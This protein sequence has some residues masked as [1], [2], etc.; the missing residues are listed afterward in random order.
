MQ[1]TKNALLLALLSTLLS[2]LRKARDMTVAAPFWL[3][4]FVAFLL[5]L[6]MVRPFGALMAL[7]MGVVWCC[8]NMPR[9]RGFLQS[10]QR[11]LGGCGE[12]R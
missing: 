12:E 7:S 1:K 2:A 9:V 6:F 11:L 8:G 3:M 4:A 10:V 5:R